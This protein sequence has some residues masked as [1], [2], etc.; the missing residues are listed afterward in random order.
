MSRTGVRFAATLA[1]VVAVVSVV[2]C[3]SESVAGQ[4]GAEGAVV[5]EPVFSPCDDIPDDALR[6]IGVDPATEDRDILGVKQPRWNI[7][8]WQGDRYSLSV[9]ATTYAVDDF[10]ANERYEE[11][12][13]VDVNGRGG[14][15][16]RE[17]A[18]EKREGCDVAVPS[19]AGA[20]LVSIGFHVLT[21]ARDAQE[22]CEVAERAMRTISSVI[23]E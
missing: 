19:A 16:F 17:V 12:V 18:D 3:G 7:C 2:G 10:R 4:A 6:Q 20:V 11:F 5:G 8:G 9:F 1:G 21:P 14:V 15:G 13:D 22:S 23:P